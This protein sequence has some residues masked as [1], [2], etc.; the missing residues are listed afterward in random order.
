MKGVVFTEFM[1]MVENTF[2]FD[3]ANDLVEET[4]P[5]SGG[6][7]TAVGTYPHEEMVNYVVKL[8]EKSKM[9]VN[10]LLRAFGEYLF[11]TFTETRKE[12]FGHTNHVLDFLEGIE[13][14]IHVEV[15]KLY[16][17]AELPRFDSERINESELKMIYKSSRSMWPLAEGLIKGCG[18]YFKQ[19]VSIETI[20]HDDAGSEATFMVS[21]DK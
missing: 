10:N 9:P 16:P 2:G 20:V 3:M 14:Y 8:S 7:Y 17:D 11:K 19:P 5:K 6:V 12:F 21:L 18:V 13:N 15:L 4:N 1:H